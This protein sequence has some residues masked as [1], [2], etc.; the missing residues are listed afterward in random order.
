MNKLERAAMQQALEALQEYRDTQMIKAP[1]R[2]IT[3]LREA[4]DP[5]LQFVRDWNEG[6]VRRVSDGKVMGVAE[7]ATQNIGDG[8]ML[9]AMQHPHNCC[10]L[11]DDV[12]EDSIEQV[13]QTEQQPVGMVIGGVFE[14]WNDDILSGAHELYAAPFNCKGKC[15]E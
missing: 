5:E 14:P 3:A 1:R 13:E 9:T 8:V 12:S 6:K 11:V 7:Q 15:C 2:A 4:L 10:V